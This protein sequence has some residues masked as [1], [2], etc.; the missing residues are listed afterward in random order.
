MSQVLSIPTNSTSTSF[1]VQSVF[2]AALEKYENKTKN[3]LFTH[4][5]A[6]QLQSCNSPTEILSILEV[7]VQQFDQGRRYNDRLQSWLNPTVNVLYAF[8]ATL[9]EGVGLVNLRPLSLQDLYSDDYFLG[10]LTWES[11][12]CWYWGPSF[13]GQGRGWERGCPR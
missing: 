13:G 4:P 8:S 3:K 12:I 11:N 6:A 1:N 7:L 5:L 2:N 10:I 9:G